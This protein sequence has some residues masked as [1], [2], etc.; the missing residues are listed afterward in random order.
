MPPH[1]T[2]STRKQLPWTTRGQVLAKGQPTKDLRRKSLERRQWQ[3]E[4]RVTTTHLAMQLSITKVELSQTGRA[5]P[6]L[7][8]RRV[9]STPE[10][11]Y[12]ASRVLT[13]PGTDSAAR[14]IKSTSSTQETRSESKNSRKLTTDK[15][16]VLKAES[17]FRD[18]KKESWLEEPRVSS[19]SRSNLP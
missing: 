2:R 10:K 14:I 9:T 12:Q 3:V 19:V 1:S 17:K 6:T 16:L 13:L 18:S 8:Q 4:F 11:R 5:L 7:L 15:P